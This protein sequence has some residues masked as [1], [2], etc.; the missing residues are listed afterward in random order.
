VTL[1]PLV[2]AAIVGRTCRQ[3]AHWEL[4]RG[5]SVSKI[6]R[7]MGSTTVFGTIYTSWTLRSINLI[8]IGLILVW[9]LSPLAAQAILRILSAYHA[10]LITA[11]SLHYLNF[12]ST[13]EMTDLSSWNWINDPADEMFVGSLVTAKLTRGSSTDIWGNVKVPL[14]SSLSGTSNSTDWSIVSGEDIEYT[15]QLG[16]P[17]MGLLQDGST[18]TNIWTSYMEIQ[19]FNLHDSDANAANVSVLDIPNITYINGTQEGAWIKWKSFNFF[20]G[21]KRERNAV[22]EADCSVISRGVSLDVNCVRT[23]GGTRYQGSC[24]ATRIRQ[25]GDSFLPQIFSNSSVFDSFIASIYNTVPMGQ[26]STPSV[27]DYW[28]SDPYGAYPDLSANITL[29]EMK[30]EVF[31]R[32]LT[33]I[34]NSFYMSRLGYQFMTRTTFLGT[35]DEIQLST[36]GNETVARLTLGSAKFSLAFGEGM[37]VDTDLTLHT[38][39]GWITAFILTIV[40]MVMASVMTFYLSSVTLIPEILG[41]VSSL[42]RDNSHIPVDGVS[43]GVGGLRRTQLLGRLV[44]RMGD[45]TPEE[46]VGALAVGGLSSTTRSEARR[47]Y[48]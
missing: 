38:N 14:V 9:L 31:S 37:D 3:L 2:F 33:Q 13:D 27:L 24:A 46:D 26:V 12:T 40:V 16:V 18:T 41:Y 10:K 32:R 6:Q 39:P 20:N 15:S 23:G 36:D 17:I 45:T 25:S 34:I 21:S 4:Q 43:A 7:F 8:G 44:L 35:H 30:P 11:P 5:A 22:A 28:M 19:C 29:Y 1:F 48:R 42:T 47:L